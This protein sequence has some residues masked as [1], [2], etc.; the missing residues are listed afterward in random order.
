MNIPNLDNTTTLIRLLSD[1]YQIRTFQTLTIQL[2]DVPGN[3]HTAAR[4]API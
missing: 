1:S 2:T 4:H 3:Y